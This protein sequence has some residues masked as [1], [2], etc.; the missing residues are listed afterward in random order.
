ML[1]ALQELYK[2][3]ESQ[4]DCAPEKRVVVPSASSTAVQ[5]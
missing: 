2:S 5:I 3:R 4:P 1:E